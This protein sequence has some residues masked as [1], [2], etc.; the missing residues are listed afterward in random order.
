[1]DGTLWEV[2]RLLLVGDLRAGIR[3]QMDISRGI[4]GVEE[5]IYFGS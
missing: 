2:R 5:G 4:T 1:M 3:Y